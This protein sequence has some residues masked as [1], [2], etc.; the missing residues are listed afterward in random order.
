M[1][2]PTILF[3]ICLVA[4][5]IIGIFI[6][7]KLDDTYPRWVRYMCLAP[8]LAA[9]VTLH[10]IILGTYVA[11]FPDLLILLALVSNYVM[12]ASKMAG[13]P[14]SEI[15]NKKEEEI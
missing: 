7:A 13:V 2:L 12:L 15:R 10:S 3:E 14:I 4:L 5:M 11:Y 6:A 1:I 9:A 8:C